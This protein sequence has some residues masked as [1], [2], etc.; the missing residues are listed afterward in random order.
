MGLLS[1]LLR[2]A[3]CAFALLVTALGLAPAALAQGY[4]VRAI[5]IVVPYPP[6]GLIDLVARIIQ[7]KL[8][9]ELGQPMLVDNR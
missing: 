1:V 5:T 2:L 4:P 7:P 8:Q 6:G 3:A 9:A